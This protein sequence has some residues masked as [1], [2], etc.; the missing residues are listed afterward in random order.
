MRSEL[1]VRVSAGPQAQNPTNAGIRR[2]G[3]GIKEQ[4]SIDQKGA[5]RNCQH[6]ASEFRVVPRRWRR[7]APLAFPAPP[8]C[9]WD[10]KRH[11]YC[12]EENQEITAPRHP[13]RRGPRTASSR[14]WMFGGFPA[15]WADKEYET[16][17]EK[18]FGD[19]KA[20][21]RL[22]I[23]SPSSRK[24]KSRLASRAPRDWWRSSRLVFA[25]RRLHHQFRHRR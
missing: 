25:P 14:S 8:T 24:T 2:E 17:F 7:R 22:V 15:E 3:R 23:S 1:P 21:Q 10:L 6:Q 4:H 12:R 13:E 11:Y 16:Y 5:D 18:L 19:D 9:I 20:K